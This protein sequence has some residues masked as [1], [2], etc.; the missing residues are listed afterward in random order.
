MTDHRS[1]EVSDRNPHECTDGHDCEHHDAE[2]EH[3]PVA[4][5][6]RSFTVI[7]STTS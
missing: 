5:T 3:C 2:H 6:T 7:T 1:V 4:G